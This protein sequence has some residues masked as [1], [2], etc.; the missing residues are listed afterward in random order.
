MFMQLSI[1]L[2][3]SHLGRLAT[4][5]PLMKTPKAT[6]KLFNLEK[7]RNWL[8]PLSL[9][10]NFPYVPQGVDATQYQST[11]DAFEHVIY[12]L[13]QKL[14]QSHVFILTT[15]DSR[16]LSAEGSI[17]VLERLNQIGVSKGVSFEMPFAGINALSVCQVTGQTVVVN[18][19]EHTLD[20]FHEWTC[21]CTPLIVRNTVNYHEAK[22]FVGS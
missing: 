2:V 8:N 18:G 20:F 6:R 7:K 1:L 5:A 17:G 14:S 4:Q 12:P 11:Y 19:F 9:Q 13:S 22:D 15:E 3:V 21:I 16:L 10:L